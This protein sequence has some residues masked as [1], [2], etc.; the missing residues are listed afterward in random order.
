VGRKPPEVNSHGHNTIHCPGSYDAVLA[1]V[2]REAIEDPYW[3]LTDECCVPE[4][5]EAHKAEEA[6]LVAAEIELRRGQPVL[7]QN[8]QLPTGVSPLFK[9]FSAP[10]RCGFTVTLRFVRRIPLNVATPRLFG[11]CGGSWTDD[12]TWRDVGGEAGVVW[13]SD[14]AGGE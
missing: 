13:S 9:G 10:W 6:T 1:E 5:D 12:S 14:R 4:L 11:G 3:A 2:V 7:C 8:W